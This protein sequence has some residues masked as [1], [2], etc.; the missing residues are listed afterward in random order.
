MLQNDKP[1]RTEPQAPDF[2]E[3]RRACVHTLTELMQNEHTELAQA[4]LWLQMADIAAQEKGEDAP[5]IGA[6]LSSA[7]AQISAP[8]LPHDAVYGDACRRFAPQF[9]KFGREAY[10][11]ELLTAASML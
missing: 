4:E 6:Y 2:F 10:A 8:D 1:I 11:K 3:A 5:E 9:A 7:Q